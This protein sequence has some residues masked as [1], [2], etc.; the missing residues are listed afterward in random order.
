LPTRLLVLL[1]ILVASAPARSVAEPSPHGAAEAIF[2][3]GGSAGWALRQIAIR[4]DDGTQVD[5]SYQHVTFGVSAQAFGLRRWVGV[6]ARAFVDVLA[7]LDIDRTNAPVSFQQV[8]L[9]AELAPVFTYVFGDVGVHA[10]AGLSFAHW[11]RGSDA[12]E[13][14]VVAAQE[15]LLVPVTIGATIDAGEVLVTP[16]IGAGFGIWYDS[17]QASIRDA[18]AAGTASVQGLDLW[19]TL[20]IA[21]PL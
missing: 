14:V 7:A 6:R 10:S 16:E 8:T 17:E 3:V 12:D 20:T 1:G 2:D 15:Q 21:A 9:R 5:L 13:T 4:H 11:F 18:I 19:F